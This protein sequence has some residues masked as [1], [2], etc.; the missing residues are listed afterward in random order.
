MV[1]VRMS[2]LRTTAPA[3]QAEIDLRQDVALVPLA[4]PLIAGP[5]SFASVI[6]LMGRTAGDPLAMLTVIGVLL[7][8]M[9]ILLIA[10]LA[11]ST[12]MDFLGMSGVAV[13]GRVFGIVLAALGVQF[14]V[15]GIAESFPAL[16]F[17]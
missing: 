9:A 1:L 8:V 10:L 2:P 17:G 13:L 5:G 16:V 7:S 11:A 14:I 12:I 4:I 6:L 15:S 3:E